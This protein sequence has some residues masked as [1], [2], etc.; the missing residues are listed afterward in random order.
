M[1][2]HAMETPGLTF[3]LEI[4]VLDVSRE[5]SADNFLEFPRACFGTFPQMRTDGD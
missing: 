1:P 3:C 4:Q 2:K 5:A